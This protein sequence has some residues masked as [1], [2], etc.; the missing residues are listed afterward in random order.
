VARTCKGCKHWRYLFEGH[1]CHYAYDM[2]IAGKI[3][4]TRECS[5]QNCDKYDNEKYKGERMPMFFSEGKRHRYSEE[6]KSNILKLH[7]EGIKNIDIANALE[8]SQST[9]TRILKGVS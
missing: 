7:R 1:A 9:V 8:V 2:A 4:V 6:T 5:A 3:G